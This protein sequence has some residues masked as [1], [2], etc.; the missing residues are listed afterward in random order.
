MM[1]SI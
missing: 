1:V